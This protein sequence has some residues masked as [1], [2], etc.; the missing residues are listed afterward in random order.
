MFV[1]LNRVRT[2]LEDMVIMFLLYSKMVTLC[3]I[4]RICTN[5]NSIGRVLASSGVVPGLI[6]SQGPR[7]T[8]D[9]IKMVRVIPLFSTQH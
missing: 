4:F 6:T 5:F 8:K 2:V 7:H 3:L 9:V 1:S